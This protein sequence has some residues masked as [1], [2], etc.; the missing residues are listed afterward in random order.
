MTGLSIPA[1]PLPQLAEMERGEFAEAN[2]EEDYAQHVLPHALPQARLL[3]QVLAFATAVFVV[4]D[5]N[6]MSVG[7]TF[8]ALFTAR[9]AVVASGMFALSQM[10]PD[11]SPRT[12][13][14][15]VF[16]FVTAVAVFTGGV[17]PLRAAAIVSYPVVGFGL[18]LLVYLALPIPSRLQTVPAAISSLGVFW[19]TFDSYESGITRLGVALLLVGGNI[20]GYLV[21]S[22][23]DIWQRQRF[24]AIRGQAEAL[25]RLEQ[26]LAEVQ[27]L[28]GIL[29]ICSHCK[30]VRDDGGYWHQVEVYMHRR[31][32]AQFSHSICP[33]CMQRHYPEHAEH[34]AGRLG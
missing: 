22:Q 15:H 9:A 17:A 12:I 8:W 1:V 20:V 19:W 27:T 24:L 7:P 28:Q 10:R 2:L 14:N 4:S 21:S 26:A 6:L 34:V 25:G 23:L 3:C 16:L 11:A 5:L 32:A 33:D 30:S 29:P 13:R 31:S 18:V